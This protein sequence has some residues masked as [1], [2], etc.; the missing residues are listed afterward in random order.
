ML[1]YKILFIL[2]EGY[3]DELFFTDLIK[4]KLIQKFDAVILKQ[5]AGGSKHWIKDI[6]RGEIMGKG[7]HYIYIIDREE[8]DCV[9]LKLHKTLE[10]RQ[11]LEKN[12]IMV[13]VIEIESWFLALLNEE[14]CN[15][16]GFKEYY[17]STDNIN[18]EEFKSIMPN[19]YKTRQDCF[20]DILRH[21]SR[22]KEEAIK[23]AK[24]K[25]ASFNYFMTRFLDKNQILH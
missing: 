14:D 7:G 17:N 22:K 11:Y 24:K 25:N 8:F 10:K 1:E 23:E 6:V 4:P 2:V 13:V 12:K 9:S 18:K 16:L 3:D 5:H 15:S 19:H 21:I 20:V